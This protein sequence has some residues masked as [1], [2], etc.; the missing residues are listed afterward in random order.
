MS[1]VHAVVLIDHQR[2]RIQRFDSESVTT[3]TLRVHSTHTR[4]H[5]S[6]VRT[7]HAFFGEVCTAVEGTAEVLVT[8]SHNAQTH[9]RRYVHRHRPELGVHLV[10]WET[11][12]DPSE[13][14]LLSF[15]RKYF[16]AH[17]RTSGTMAVAMAH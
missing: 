3:R 11:V 2:A 4:Q 13:G 9:F 17:E 8:G 10:G 7:L 5:G 12:D 16:A 1:D 15:A 6:S 14:Q